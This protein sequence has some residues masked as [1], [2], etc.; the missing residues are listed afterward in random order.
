MPWTPKNPTHAGLLKAAIP[1]Y[2]T[3]ACRRLAA[4]YG[5]ILASTGGKDLKARMGFNPTGANYYD[6]VPEERRRFAADAMHMV[7]DTPCAFRAEVRQSYST[8]LSLIIEATGFPLISNEAG[9]DGF[10]IF[11]DQAVDDSIEIHTDRRRLLGANVEQRD[12]IDLGAG[13]KTDFVDMVW[14]A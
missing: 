8:G 12:L 7:I 14:E 6:Y 1:R 4:G 10:I 11:A 2:R 5:D 13:I 9:V 3:N